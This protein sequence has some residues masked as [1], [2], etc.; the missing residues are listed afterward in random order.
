[1]K[2]P[3]FSKINLEDYS[4]KR[5]FLKYRGNFFLGKVISEKILDKENYSLIWKGDNE[6]KEGI[7]EI[8]LRKENLKYLSKDSIILR[9]KFLPF[10]FHA[11]ECTSGKFGEF[12]KILNQD[13]LVEFS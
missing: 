3:Y 1:M 13:S 4:N 10:W 5:I 9:D 7:R 6:G 2:I 11:K 12:E 8:P